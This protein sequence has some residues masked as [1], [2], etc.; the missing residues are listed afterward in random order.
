M[1]IEP[2]KKNPP[3]KAGLLLWCVVML[4]LAWWPWN[5]WLVVLGVAYA[6]RLQGGSYQASSPPIRAKPRSAEP[7][8]LKRV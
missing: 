5:V 2:S 8:P 1:I 3:W 4:L 7:E 6:Y